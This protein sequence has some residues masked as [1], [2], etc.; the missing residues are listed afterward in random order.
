M[1]IAR[2]PLPS[3]GNVVNAATGAGHRGKDAVEAWANAFAGLGI[4][5]ALVAFL[6]AV[7]AWDAPAWAVASLF[8]LASV[9]R[10]YALRRLFRWLA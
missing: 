2:A 1:S 3:R 8:F 7:G 9:A 10:S 4:S 5:L 6:R